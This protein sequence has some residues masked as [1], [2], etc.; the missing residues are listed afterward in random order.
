[1]TMIVLATA[2]VFLII[3]S[4]FFSSSEVAYFYLDPLEIRRMRETH[5]EMVRRVEQAGFERVRHNLLPMERNA[6]G[7]ALFAM[8]A[9]TAG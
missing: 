3:G 2:L 5:P 8:T 1:M 7:P 4:A 6:K 9:R